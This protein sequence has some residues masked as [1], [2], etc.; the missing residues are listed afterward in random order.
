MTHND[1]NMIETY[2]LVLNKIQGLSHT[3]PSV[4]DMGAGTGYFAEILLKNGYQNITINSHLKNS[5]IEKRNY[6]DLNSPIPSEIILNYD[7]ITALDVIEHLLNPFEFLKSCEKLM[8]KNGRII[9]STPNI[10]SLRSKIAFFLKGRYTGFFG[11]NFN[12][13]H[14]IYDQHIWPANKHIIQYYS[15]LNNLEI[16]SKCYVPHNSELFGYTS[17]F[18]LKR[19]QS[20]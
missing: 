18:I 15:K 2:S 13:G 1:S 17:I 10:H 3:K 12:S 5:N 16:E 8:T 11:R 9:I 6:W 4:I 14:P 7:V 20:W 19:A